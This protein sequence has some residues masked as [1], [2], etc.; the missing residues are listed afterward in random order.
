MIGAELRAFD[1][2]LIALLAYA[3]IPAV[4]IE[5]VRGELLGYLVGSDPL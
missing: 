4:L 1:A 2:A 5:R 3:G